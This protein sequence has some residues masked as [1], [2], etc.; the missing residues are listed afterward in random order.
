MPHSFQRP[1][2]RHL[3]AERRPVAGACPEL[4][5]RR[6]ARRVPGPLRGR[7]VRRPQVPGLP[8]VGQPR[9][10]AAVWLLHAAGRRDRAEPSQLMLG[11]DVGGTFT[12]VVCVRDGTITVTKVPSDAGDPAAPV[13]EGARRLGTAGHEV[14]NHAST[15][16]LNAVITR[17][18]AEGRLPDHR[19]PPRHARPRPH[20]AP[21]GVADRPVVAALVRRRGAAAGAALPAPR[22][23]SSGCSPTAACYLPLD[24]AAGAHPARGARGAATSRASRSA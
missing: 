11:V 3:E 18:P 14:F 24:E 23:S 16:G 15:M 22:R 10:G 5:G 17:T 21:A 6:P 8:G 7:L 9:A 19:G 1:A 4:R 2:Q 12:D 13:V 20:L